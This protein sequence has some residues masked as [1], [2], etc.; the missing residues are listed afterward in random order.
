MSKVWRASGFSGLGLISEFSHSPKGSIRQQSECSEVRLHS[1]GGI[2]S[3]DGLAASSALLRIIGF[4][5]AIQ[6]DD[7]TALEGLRIGSFTRQFAIE[8]VSACALTEKHSCW[9]RI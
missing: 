8:F 1:K 6:P 2:I 7:N 9:R 4:R 5:T 3:S